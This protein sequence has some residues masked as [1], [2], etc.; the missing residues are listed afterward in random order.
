MADMGRTYAFAVAVTRRR[1]DLRPKRWFR[2]KAGYRGGRKAHRFPGNDPRDESRTGPRRRV[3]CAFDRSRRR[4]GTAR[5]R[6]AR[7]VTLST[8]RSQLQAVL[9]KAGCRRQSEVVALLG[10]LQPL[11]TPQL[12]VDGIPRTEDDDG[13]PGRLQQ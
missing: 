4:R 5:L 8:L 11:I 9:A 10:R 2:P 12:Q 13:T 1:R 6:A 3:T 7:R